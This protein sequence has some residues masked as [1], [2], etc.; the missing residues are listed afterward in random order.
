L[1][2]PGQYTISVVVPVF[3]SAATLEELVSR[4]T[5]VLEAAAS[6]YEIIL[7]DDGSGDDSRAV[8]ARLA[9]LNAHVRP[10]V[11]SRNFGQHNALLCGIREARYELIATLDDDLQNPPEDI[12]RLLEALKDDVD[13]VYGTPRDRRHDGWRWGVSALV[14][15]ALANVMGAT[16]ARWVSPFRLFRASIRD[17][18]AAYASSFVAI[19]VLLSWGTTRVTSVQVDH[20]ARRAGRSNYRIR[21]LLILALNTLTGFS[22]R[23]LQLASILGLLAIMLGAGLFAVVLARAILY[24]RPASGSLFLASLVFVFSGTQLFALGIIGEY[25][26][27]MHFRTM[28]RPPY[29]VRTDLSRMSRK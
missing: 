18:F 27:R 4:V 25:L 20:Y 1:T 10:L 15:M 17:S 19:D 28:G 26:A 8:L 21:T 22:A 5:A 2:T 16:T 12:P 14:R 7:V 23:P 6:D 24:D 9:D 29:V 11:L 3:N 13:V